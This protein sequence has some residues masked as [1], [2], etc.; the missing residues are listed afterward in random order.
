MQSMSIQ[1]SRKD[2]EIV[3]SPIV[4]AG[5]PTFLGIALLALMVV[6]LRSRGRGS[7]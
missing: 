7:R 2:E 6:Y 4:I 1:P 5:G 3:F